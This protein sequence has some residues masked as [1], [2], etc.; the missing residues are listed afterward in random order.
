MNGI[1]KD[2]GCLSKLYMT[3]TLKVY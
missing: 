3:Y 2:V 1:W